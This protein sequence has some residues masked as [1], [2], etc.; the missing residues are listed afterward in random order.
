MA[1]SGAHLWEQQ[2]IG[3]VPMGMNIETGSRA[4]PLWQRNT[5]P[6][7]WGINWN[8]KSFQ[9]SPKAGYARN[10]PVAVV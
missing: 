1:S 6:I 10:T 2:E 9:Q 5:W 4:A 3:L 7:I 8:L